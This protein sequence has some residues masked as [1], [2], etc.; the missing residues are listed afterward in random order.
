M[1]PASGR[2][3]ETPANRLI[4]RRELFLAQGRSCATSVPFVDCDSI[5][6]RRRKVTFRMRAARLVRTSIYVYLT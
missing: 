2:S 6:R 4:S 1:Q 5:R 3:N